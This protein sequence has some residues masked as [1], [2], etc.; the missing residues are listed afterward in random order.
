MNVLVIGSGGREH[1]LLK[2][3]LASPLATRVIAAP[4]NGGMEA[5]AQCFPLNVEDLRQA[6]ELAK[7]EAVD[8][9]IVGPEVPLALGMADALRAAGVL[10]YGPGFKG[11]QLEASKAVCKDFFAKYGIPTA[12]SRTFA[13]ADMPEALDYVAAQPLPI[14]VKASGLAAGKGVIIAQS[15]EEAVEATRGMLDGSMFGSAGQEVVIEE[16]LV[17]EEASI[18]LMVCKDRYVMLPAAQ[19]HKRV[20]EGDTGPNTGGMGAYAPAPVVTP[21]IE[22]RI[23]REVIEPTMRGFVA[24][25]YDFRGTLFI[26]IM[27]TADGPMV[28]EFNVRFGD[29]ETQVVLPMLDADPLALMLDCAR[30]T[31]D[32]ASVGI[33]PGSSIVVVLAAKGYPGKYSKGDVIGLP[34]DLPKDTFIVH[35]GTKRLPDGTI[36]S[37]GG[38]VLGV[39]ARAATL[40]QAADAA[41]AAADKVQWQNKYL[42]RDIGHRAGVQMR[43]RP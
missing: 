32:P 34:N 23:V 27:V 30:G 36:V 25:A 22:R 13:S 14:V 38:R 24:E 12:R 17:G 21:E 3:C 10:V 1:A 35:A 19:D 29:P 39:M 20:G 42:R 26:G 9:A 16:C 7:R 41:Y 15:R 6:V 2:A 31:L 28:L 11:A 5:E 37:S 18:T 33:R 40:Q 43:T 4:G 8:M